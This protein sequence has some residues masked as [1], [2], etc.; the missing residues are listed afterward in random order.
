MRFSLAEDARNGGE[1]ENQYSSHHK[2]RSAVE[3][4]AFFF[5]F[6]HININYLIW[7]LL[8]PCS[9]SMRTK[10][11]LFKNLHPSKCHILLIQSSQ[12]NLSSAF[13]PPPAIPGSFVIL[14]EDV[15]S[16]AQNHFQWELN[17]NPGC[18]RLLCGSKLDIPLY[19]SRSRRVQ[20][21]FFRSNPPNCSFFSFPNLINSSFFC[22][23]QSFRMRKI[24][25]FI[26][27]DT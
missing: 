2:M 26:R 6:L 4:D 13:L 23:M 14:R 22:H 11:Y 24:S 27:P 1:K 9:I 10:A 15:I 21:L 12:N 17:S 5:F 18:L 16:N 19:K 3:I 25:F 20:V 8:S 7:R